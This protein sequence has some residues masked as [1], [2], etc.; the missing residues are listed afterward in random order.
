MDVLE[1]RDHHGLEAI[2]HGREVHKPGEVSLGRLLED[3]WERDHVTSKQVQWHVDDWGESY[4][5]C[6]MVENTGKRVAHG[7]GGLDHE[8]Q[9]EV[10]GDELRQRVVK[11][12]REV[13]HQ[14]E[15]EG[16]EHHDRDLGNELSCSVDPDVV[17]A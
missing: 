3:A 9:D 14:E 7:G 15:E 11:A 4:S 6:L 1:L 16:D 10:V 13:G 2:S 17:H 8:H 12:N 5:S